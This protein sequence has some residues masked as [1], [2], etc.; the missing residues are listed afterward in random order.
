MGLPQ[1]PAYVPRSYLVDSD[2]WKT[3]APEW[4]SNIPPGLLM[5]LKT[6]HRLAWEV[7]QWIE[8][9]GLARDEIASRLGMSRGN[10]WRLLDGYSPISLIQAGDWAALIGWELQ[11]VA[12]TAAR[13]DSPK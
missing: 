6:H 13:T 8:N 7:R 3:R 12:P 10:L 5:A 2:A 11:L 9:K 4:K 1:R